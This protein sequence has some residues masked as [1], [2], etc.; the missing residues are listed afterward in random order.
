MGSPV[1][2]QDEKVIAT[3]DI[4]PAN[5]GH[6]IVFPTEHYN[7]LF[8][9]PQEDFLHLF[10]VVRACTVALLHTITPEGVNLLT[11][12]GAAA[13]QRVQHATVHIV[14]REKGDEVNIGWKPL[15]MSEDQLKSVR[16][17]IRS[18][19]KTEEEQLKQRSKRGTKGPRTKRTQ[20]PQRTRRS[21]PKRKTQRESRSK[22]KEETEEEELEEYER[23]MP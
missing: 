7:V 18:Y 23:F 15:E 16:K 2:Y 20:K 22:K 5:E 13:G 9:M 3:L 11:R 6:I 4:R 19:F 21:Q 14:P 8:Q 17:E 1:I 12:S 10:A